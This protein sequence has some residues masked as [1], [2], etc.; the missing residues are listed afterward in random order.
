VE[1]E[2]MSSDQTA[3]DVTGQQPEGGA[4]RVSVVWGRVIVGFILSATG[5]AAFGHAWTA[6]AATWWWLGAMSL[7]AGG[8][9]LLSV[10]YARR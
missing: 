5:G 2:A 1:I 7:L 4:G 6:H 8:L 10:A 3:T 9:L